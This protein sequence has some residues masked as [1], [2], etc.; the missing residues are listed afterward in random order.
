MAT[1]Y[2]K[3]DGDDGE[4]GLSEPNAWAT[5]DKAMNTVVGGDKVNIK[6]GT[7]ANCV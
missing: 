1:Y 4:D 7:N 3:T 5:I 6:T 2:V